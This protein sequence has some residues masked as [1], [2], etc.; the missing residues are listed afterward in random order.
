MKPFLA[1]AAAAGVTA[2]VPLAAAGV[3]SVACAFVSG[4]AA[5]AAVA[6]TA[7]HPRYRRAGGGAHMRVA[8]LLLDQVIAQ[9]FGGAMVARARYLAA[10]RLIDQADRR[11]TG[12]AAVRIRP[13]R[14]VRPVLPDPAPDTETDTSLKEAP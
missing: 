3:P 9:G 2:W 1:A 11:A 4:A 7:A 10:H 14:F 8:R 6:V 12:V 5:A 13:G